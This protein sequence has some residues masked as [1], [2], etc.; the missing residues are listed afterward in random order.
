[1]SDKNKTHLYRNPNSPEAIEAR[2]QGLPDP[3]PFQERL[4]IDDK[5]APLIEV[6]K[7]RFSIDQKVALSKGGKNLSKQLIRASLG[8][9][10]N[11]NQICTLYYF[12]SYRLQWLVV[13]DYINRPLPPDPDLYSE[14]PWPRP[15]YSGTYGNFGQ[16]APGENWRNQDRSMADIEAAQKRV[17]KNVTIDPKADREKEVPDDGQYEDDFTG[18]R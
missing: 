9:D 12:D 7:T 4:I 16:S 15:T 6:D 17:Y 8:K 13:K 14:T 3:T 18:A 5:K 2:L 11:G 10:Q 1:M